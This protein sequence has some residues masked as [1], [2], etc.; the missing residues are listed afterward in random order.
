MFYHALPQT[1]TP[2]GTAPPPWWCFHAETLTPIHI[3]TNPDRSITFSVVA[4]PADFL[5]VHESHPGSFDPG[6]IRSVLLP[7]LH[8]LIP[9]ATIGRIRNVPF[10]KARTHL[11][12][13]LI[14]WDVA[15][16]HPS[17][18]RTTDP[19]FIIP[20]DP[21]DERILGESMPYVRTSTD[22]SGFGWAYFW[23]DAHLAWDELI[24]PFLA[25]P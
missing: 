9:E 15:G 22:H 18:I 2:P 25:D 14:V 8:I 23:E 10:A 11:P 7:E 17:I 1:T 16:R 13:Y 6:I 19:F 20:A 3:K 4:P 12:E 5:P 24:K 21:K